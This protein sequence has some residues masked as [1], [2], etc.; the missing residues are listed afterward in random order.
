MA[1]NLGSARSQ[2]LFRSRHY[3][4]WLILHFDG[5]HGSFRLLQCLG[6][7]RHNR[8][9][10]IPDAVFAKHRLIGRKDPNAIGALDIVRRDHRNHARHLPRRPLSTDLI[11]A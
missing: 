9:S 11:L 8:V 5:G 10:Q 2:S 7:Y 3:R 6:G 1:V 4:Q